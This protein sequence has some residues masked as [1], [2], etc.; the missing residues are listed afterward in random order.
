[1]QPR[2]DLPSTRHRAAAW[3]HRAGKAIKKVLGPLEPTGAEHPGT[4]GEPAFTP[5]CVW[6]GRAMFCLYL[7]E[8]FS[9]P[10]RPGRS[11][12]DPASTADPNPD[13]E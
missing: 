10:A 6:Y 9:Q 3:W 1:M 4:A 7:P 12:H 2:A 8:P 11:L 13:A 5:T